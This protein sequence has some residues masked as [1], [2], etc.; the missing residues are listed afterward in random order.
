[1]T[2]FRSARLAFGKD[3]IPANNGYGFSSFRYG[4]KG[5]LDLIHHEGGHMTQNLMFKQRYDG[6]YRTPFGES[7]EL[8][9]H[10]YMLLLR[11][12]E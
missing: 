1:M 2:V 5:F 3:G 12:Y 6:T 8:K 9:A 11:K 10:K 7:K 4:R